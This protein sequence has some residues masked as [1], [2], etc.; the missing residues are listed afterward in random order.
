MALRVYVSLPGKPTK[1]TM[2]EG[3][4]AGGSTRRLVVRVDAESRTTAQLE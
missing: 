1:A 3:T 4:L 2:V